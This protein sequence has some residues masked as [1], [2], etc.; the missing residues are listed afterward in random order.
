MVKKYRFGMPIETEAVI[1]DVPCEEG[2]PEIGEIAFLTRSG[3]GDED[4]IYEASR[5]GFAYTL[6]LEQETAVYGLGETVRGINKKGW[7]Y[8]SENEDNGL[9][10]E[11]TRSLYGSHNFVV[12]SG[13][14]SI[15]L[16]F[17]YPGKME[18]DIA[19]TH[20]NLLAVSCE[21]ADLDLYVI[22]GDSMKAVVKEFR[23]L[24][25]RSYI[26]PKWALGYAQ[27]RFGYVTPKD[28]QEVVDDHRKHHIPLDAMYM[29][30]DYMDHFKDF[31]V[32]G[33]NFPDFPKFV[34]QMR[35]QGIHLV[36][37]I[38]A[39]VA[40]EQ[41]Y[42]VCDQGIENG[43]FCTDA[44]GR[45]YITGCWPGL[46]LHPDF[47]NSEVRRWFGDLY[48]TLTDQG[49]DGF[50]NDMNEPALFYSEQSMRRF[51]EEM[52]EL[53]AR[54]VGQITTFEIYDRIGRLSGSGLHRCFYH[55]MDGRRIRHDRVHNLYGYNMTKA[56]AEGLKRTMPDKRMLLFS[57]SSYVGMH[58][59]GGIW[60]G[61]N[62]AWWSHLLLNIQMS[63][64][65]NITGFLYNGADIGGFGSDTSRDLLLRWLAFGVF[66]PLM[67][68]HSSS[69]TRPQECYQFENPE[70]FSHVIGVRY[71]LL[72]YLYSEYVKACLNDD[73]YF[74]SLAFDFP[75]DVR[76]C[77][78]EDQLM[79]GEGLMVAPVYTQN[80]D[81]RTVYLP[82]DMLFVKFMPDGSIYQ[83]KMGNGMHYIE[84]ELNEVPLFVLKDHILPVAKPAENV[85]E[86]DEENLETIGWVT[87]PVSYTL[88]HDD[89]YGKDYGNE[90]HY[91]EI[92]AGTV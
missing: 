36:P 34:G 47:L 88:Y 80:A 44:D 82:E 58:R 57:R 54:P 38:D 28:F 60:Q 67:R 5:T 59:Y 46:T 62:K 81:G 13:M 78:I 79:L 85:E 10:L 17:D 24:I 14:P 51:K 32:N 7:H 86:L 87:K 49:I 92:Y 89:G 15:G 39:G 84:V 50:W 33:E 4:E 27:S 1:K 37:I 64:S 66:T 71:R 42:E 55:N 12:L 31:T 19:Y 77:H 20:S 68:N 26:A 30:I 9:H 2:M 73:M 63:V 91:R 61:D 25:G 40:K 52:G 23:G 65:L 76:A 43:Y 70:D 45:P 69:D 90:S 48:K 18:F 21:Y 83:E 35:S 53:I 56:A 74:R 8:V 6:K 29:D 11:D 41:G 22:T 75:D 3:D 16:F 72:P